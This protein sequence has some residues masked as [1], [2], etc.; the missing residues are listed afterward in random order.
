M[1]NSSK[2]KLN[3]EKST[4]FSKTR[5]RYVSLVTVLRSQLQRLLYLPSSTDRSPVFSQAF[6]NFEQ[7]HS[8]FQEFRNYPLQSFLQHEVQSAVHARKIRDFPGC[9]AFALSLSI[10]ADLNMQACSVCIFSIGTAHCICIL[11]HELILFALLSQE[12][13][14]ERKTSER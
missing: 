6:V 2:C 10:Y 1:R 12:L 3:C 11:Q 14:W 5:F 13:L 4:K 8:R 9:R 7:F